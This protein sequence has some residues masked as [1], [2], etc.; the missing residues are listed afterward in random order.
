[1]VESP[2]ATIYFSGLTAVH[3]QEGLTS[4]ITRSDPPVFLTIN[5][6]A[7]LFL[8][9]RVSRNCVVDAYAATGDN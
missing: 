9:L 7:I 4:R 2:G 1:M 8:D 3:P 6:N 5:F